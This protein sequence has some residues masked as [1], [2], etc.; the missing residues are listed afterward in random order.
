MSIPAIASIKSFI[1]M[2][3]STYSKTESIAFVF[4][5]GHRSIK[6]HVLVM[7]VHPIVNLSCVGPLLPLYFSLSRK[8]LCLLDQRP[9]LKTKHTTSIDSPGPLI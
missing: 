5:C 6:D 3:M 1:K 8:K 4:L 9:H 7:I 2:L